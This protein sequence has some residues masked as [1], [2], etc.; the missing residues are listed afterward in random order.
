MNINPFKFFGFFDKKEVDPGSK[1]KPRFSFVESFFNRIF[2]TQSSSAQLRK[3]N[4]SV[5]ISSSLYSKI[6]NFVASFFFVKPKDS[7][8]AMGQIRQNIEKGNF[9]DAAKKIETLS[10]FPEEQ[11]SI[12][13]ALAH[14]ICLKASEYIREGSFDKAAPLLE[15]ATQLPLPTHHEAIV[16][17]PLEREPLAETLYG[18]TEILVTAKENQPIYASF[19]KA[20]S[21]LQEVYLG[22]ADPDSSLEKL[23]TGIQR[24]LFLGS[25]KELKTDIGQILNGQIDAEEFTLAEDTINSSIASEEGKTAWRFILASKV[26]EIAQI[27]IAEGDFEKAGNLLAMPLLDQALGAVQKNDKRSLQDNSLCEVSRSA[28]QCKENIPLRL[29]T[30]IFSLQKAYLEK[31][32]DR[33]QSTLSQLHKETNTLKLERILARPK[34][35]LKEEQILKMQKSL[36]KGDFV[37]AGQAAKDLRFYL[38]RLDVWHLSYANKIC[39]EVQKCVLKGSFGRVQEL[40]ASPLLEEIIKS[41]H[42]PEEKELLCQTLCAMTKELIA[43][44]KTSYLPKE[45]VK[46]VF[47]LQAMGLEKSQVAL[48]QD[49]HAK[50]GMIYLDHLFAANRQ[51]DSSGLSEIQTILKSIIDKDGF[52][53]VE[54]AIYQWAT[55]APKKA[56]FF[57]EQLSNLSASSEAMDMFFEDFQLS[58]DMKNKERQLIKKG[59]EDVLKVKD[60]I[61]HDHLKEA[62]N[63]ACDI[64]H[65]EKKI[66]SLHLIAQ[67]MTILTSQELVLNLVDALPDSSR[68]QPSREIILSLLTKRIHSKEDSL[69]KLLIH[70]ASKDGPSLV[71]AFLEKLEVSTSWKQKFFE[72]IKKEAGLDQKNPSSEQKNLQMTLAT[73]PVLKEMLYEDEALFKLIPLLSAAERG[74]LKE[75]QEK[76]IASSKEVLANTSSHRMYVKDSSTK[77][78]DADRVLNYLG[79]KEKVLAQA[80]KLLRAI[81]RAEGGPSLVKEDFAD[82]IGELYKKNKKDDLPKV[83]SSLA[84]ELSLEDSN[85]AIDFLKDHRDLVLPFLKFLT[86]QDVI[87]FKTREVLAMLAEKSSDSS[88]LKKTQV[89]GVIAFIDHMNYEPHFL[90]LLSSDERQGLVLHYQKSIDDIQ[91]MRSFSTQSLGLQEKKN[92]LE[93]SLEEKIEKL[94]AIH[95]SVRS[96]ISTLEQQVSAENKEELEPAIDCL[97]EL[98]SSRKESLDDLPEKLEIGEGLSAFTIPLPAKEITVLM[99]EI[100][101]IG[102]KLKKM[103]SNFADEEEALQMK[104]AA[105]KGQEA[106]IKHLLEKLEV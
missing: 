8:D 41:D 69:E 89:E 72:L 83:F 61:T 24:L 48:L 38:Q 54:E 32:K 104:D 52:G 35:D 31:A 22:Q 73:L 44:E 106:K 58:L 85:A 57:Y 45:L 99:K 94:A 102:D 59:A 96:K 21:S 97:Y 30:R 9:A 62:I 18:L 80:E 20:I 88:N 87:N 36:E 92:E 15:L 11:K 101:E 25:R 4:F 39:E 86:K 82:V 37:T 26:Y 17:D 71:Q 84:K 65:Q 33:D 6:S 16:T 74:N 93:D 98:L 3:E 100:S 50:T 103:G 78:E 49:Y 46:K 28:I 40:L 105:L 70:I 81:K 27:C 76:L 67:K 60:L 63:Q 77:K 42:F 95:E 5:P 75:K 79:Q 47:N 53:V 56:E 55:S 12:C 10:D 29:L 66:E 51:S 90:S 43:L 14:S 2:K 7:Q 23:Q 13:L 68:S 1:D 19:L 64:E 91:K 34:R